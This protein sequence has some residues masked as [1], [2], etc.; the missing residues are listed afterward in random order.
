[1]ILNIRPTWSA[2]NWLK[3]VNHAIFLKIT[4]GPNAD[5]LRNQRICIPIVRDGAAVTNDSRAGPGGHRDVGSI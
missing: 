1:M 3:S 2:M 4:N 5:R